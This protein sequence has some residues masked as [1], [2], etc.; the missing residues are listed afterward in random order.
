[1]ARSRKDDKPKLT[2]RQS[3][4]FER[5]VKLGELAVKDVLPVKVTSIKGFGSFFRGK[6]SP[7]DVDLA[8]AQDFRIPAGAR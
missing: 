5:L 4:L 6:P 3:V 2:K 1:M 8:I 7:K